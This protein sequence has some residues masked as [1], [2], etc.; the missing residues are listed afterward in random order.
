MCRYGAAC[1]RP[2][3]HFAHPSRRPAAYSRNQFSATFGSAASGAGSPST[4]GSP[5]AGAVKGKDQGAIGAWPSESKE[6]IS[7]RLK[8]FA[9][10]DSADAD[11]ER[12]V[13]GGGDGGADGSGKDANGDDK[14]EINLDDDEEHHKKEAVKA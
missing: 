1:T 13:P 12:I 11:K 7:E 9:G 6:H 10:G 3:C 2:D 14:V 4:A 5:A 8:R